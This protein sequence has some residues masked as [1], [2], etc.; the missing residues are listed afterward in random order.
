M[1]T[2]EVKV[3]IKKMRHDLKERGGV[4]AIDLTALLEFAY[5]VANRSR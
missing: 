2:D 1:N 4:S 5:N 3:L